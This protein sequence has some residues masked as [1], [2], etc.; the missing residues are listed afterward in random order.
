MIE[1]VRVYVIDNSPIK[2]S[3]LFILLSLQ[4]QQVVEVE[5]RMRLSIF[6]YSLITIDLSQ[7]LRD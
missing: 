1:I 3:V 6:E 2:K 4:L 7:T 5:S